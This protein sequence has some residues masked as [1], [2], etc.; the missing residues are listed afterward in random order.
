[1]NPVV[2][3]RAENGDMKV[4]L[5]LEVEI[6]ESDGVGT[7]NDAVVVA[8]RHL[9]NVVQAIDS[10]DDIPTYFTVTIS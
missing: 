8:F 9:Q 7:S 5:S 2:V 3:V 1:M 4:I 10:V 6:L